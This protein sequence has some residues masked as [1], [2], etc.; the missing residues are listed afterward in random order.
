[1]AKERGLG[2]PEAEFKRSGEWDGTH[3]LHIS[4]LL[5][6]AARLV[7]VNHLEGHPVI[8]CLKSAQQCQFSLPLGLALVRV[9]QLVQQLRAPLRQLF[10]AVGRVHGCL[11]AYT[12]HAHRSQHILDARFASGCGV[13]GCK[14]ACGSRRRCSGGCG[15]GYFRGRGG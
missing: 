8:L 1:M 10:K 12:A 14:G 5:H 3:L 15:E 7:R 13:S 4:R 11:A 9:G 2:Q 6:T